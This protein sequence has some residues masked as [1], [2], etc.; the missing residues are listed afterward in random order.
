MR[1]LNIVTDLCFNLETVKVAHMQ[2]AA[3]DMTWLTASVGYCGK[4]R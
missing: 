4:L 3:L 1:I 2:V